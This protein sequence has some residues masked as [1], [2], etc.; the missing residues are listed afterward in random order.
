MIDG[1]E[2]LPIAWHEVEFAWLQKQKS[3]WD[4]LPVNPF[5]AKALHRPAATYQAFF[6]SRKELKGVGALHPFLKAGARLSQQVVRDVARFRLGSHDLAVFQGRICKP[7]IAFTK[8]ACPRCPKVES[9]RGPVGPVDTESH[10][11]FECT[12][13]A[14]VREKFRQLA[15][16]KD[17]RGLFDADDQITVAHFVSE[18]MR[19]RELA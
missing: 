3:W 19:A 9:R 13:T 2:L 11:L 10:L 17:L 6:W 18:C 5:V 1:A 7:P 15:A 12:A 14:H 16:M 8:R 4:S